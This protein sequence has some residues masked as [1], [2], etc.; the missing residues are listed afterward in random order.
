VVDTGTAVVGIVV[1]AAQQPVVGEA[2]TYTCRWRL[3][4]LRIV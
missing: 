1:C 2:T 3:S 4:F